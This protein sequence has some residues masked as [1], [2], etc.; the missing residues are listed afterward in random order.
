MPSSHI[1]HFFLLF[2][3]CVASSNQLFLPRVNLAARKIN[4]QLYEIQPSVYGRLEFV[5]QRGCIHLP[6]FLLESTSHGQVTDVELSLPD[7]LFSGFTYCFVITVNTSSVSS[8][9]VEGRFKF[10]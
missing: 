8:A 5:S 1:L 10:G 3:L 2:L 7:E 6:F 9:I 4:C